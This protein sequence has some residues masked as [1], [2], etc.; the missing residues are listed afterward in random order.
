MPEKF[1][2]IPVIP[3]INVE[4]GQDTEC[5]NFVGGAQVETWI[6]RHAKIYAELY[7]DR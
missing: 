2:R 3:A 6:K 1:Q 5:M 7:G 4:P